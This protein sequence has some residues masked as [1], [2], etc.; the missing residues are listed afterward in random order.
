MCVASPRG[1]EL[2]EMVTN[3]ASTIFGEIPAVEPVDIPARSNQQS[4]RKSLEKPRAGGPAR[5]ESA[6]S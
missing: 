4:E 3:Y 6:P 5:E 1:V 2:F